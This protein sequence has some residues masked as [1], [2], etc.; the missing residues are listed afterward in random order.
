MH[1]NNG[2]AHGRSPKEILIASAAGGVLSFGEI[3]SNGR[4]VVI[5]SVEAESVI[6]NPSY[7]LDPRTGVSGFVLPGIARGID[8]EHTKRDP[9][10]TNSVMVWFVWEQKAPLP[11]WGKRL[12][13]EDDGSKI[14]SASAAVLVPID[15]ETLT[16]DTG[17]RKAR[18]FVTG[19]QS[20]NMI[21]VEVELQEYCLRTLLGTKAPA[22]DRIACVT[23]YMP[24]QQ[25]QACTNM[26][27]TRL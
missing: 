20:L 4:I 10:A 22:K 27:S 26:L 18:L 23:L 5:D 16:S 21:A 15:E 17:T 2:L 25:Q 7:F 1:N 13:F 19:C 9:E 24:L 14:R 8:L 12:L 6:D 3:L 11:R